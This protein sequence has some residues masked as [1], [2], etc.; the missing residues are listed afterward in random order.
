MPTTSLTPVQD[1][2][3]DLK[4]FRTVPQP[5]EHGALKSIIAINPDK[6]WGLLDSLL[7]DGYLPTENVIILQDHQNNLIVKEGNRRIG[8][9]KLVFGQISII[10]IDVPAGTQQKITAV[11]QEWRSG[12]QSVPCSI[13]PETDVA[14]VDKIVAITH[15]KDQLASRDRWSSVARARHNRDMLGTPEPVLDLLEKYL[16]QALNIGPLQKERWAG[17]YPFTVLDEAIR[18]LLPR[19]GFTRIPDLVNAYPALAQRQP[20]E[21]IIREIGSGI[22]TFPAIRSTVDDVFTRFGI[23]PLPAPPPATTPTPTPASGTTTNPT[24]PPSG[25]GSATGPVQALWYQLQERTHQHQADSKP[26]QQGVLRQRAAPSITQL[27]ILVLLNPSLE[28]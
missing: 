3:L 13:Y 16:L 27:M 15:G 2:H 10:G 28:D 11:T 1:L 14:I 24:T 26:A 21:D 12:N 20:L 25:T 8:A 19:L 23:P 7:E 18:R 9:L 22:I 6:F 17:D 5:D 4:N